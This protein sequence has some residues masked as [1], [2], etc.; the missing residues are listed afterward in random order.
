MLKVL[1]CETS[2]CYEKKKAETK[3]SKIMD[4]YAQLKRFH[5]DRRPQFYIYVF[6]YDNTQT[7]PLEKHLPSTK[8]VGVNYKKIS[9][10]GPIPK[11]GLDVVTYVQRIIS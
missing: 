7:M 11:I 10:P 6:I 9:A 3:I 4:K 1:A 5:D 2:K 8:K